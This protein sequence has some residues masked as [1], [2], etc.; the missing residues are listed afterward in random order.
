MNLLLQGIENSIEKISEEFF[1]EFS[2][3]KIQFDTVEILIEALYKLCYF[4][5]AST[6][7]EANDLIEGKAYTKLIKS[8]FDQFSDSDLI[9]YSMK[10]MD[11]KITFWKN[12]QEKSETFRKAIYWVKINLEGQD[13][14][15]AHTQ[16]DFGG[17]ISS[18]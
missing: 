15:D 10:S 18:I 1:F 5:E 16:Y 3:S 12:L 4:Y 14:I 11:E 7:D 6:S 17:F 9:Y 8:L 13:L 2:T